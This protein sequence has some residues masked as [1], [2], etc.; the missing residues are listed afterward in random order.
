ME[1]NKLAKDLHFGVPFFFFGG[2]YPSK[3]KKKELEMQVLLCLGS[4][5]DFQIP[6]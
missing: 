5:L 6:T 4:A 2:G 1:K 3:L